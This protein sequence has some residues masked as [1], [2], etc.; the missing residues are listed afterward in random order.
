MTANP[1]CECFQCMRHRQPNW[2]EGF[3]PE[4]QNVIVE[5]RHYPNDAST[6]SG[7]DITQTRIDQYPYRA[8]CRICEFTIARSTFELA[9]SWSR[10][11]L[12][13]PEC[14]EHCDSPCRQCLG[15]CEALCETCGEHC[16]SSCEQCGE[17]HCEDW[18]SMCAAH[19]YHNH[20]NCENCH[21]EGYD[22]DDDDDDDY[23]LPLESYSY[24]PDPNFLGADSNL[25]LGLE[26]EVA[27]RGS[28]A[29]EWLNEFVIPKP[30]LWYAKEDSTVPGFEL[31]THPMTIRYAKT[32]LPYDAIARALD[33]GAPAT[34]DKCGTH[35]HISRNALSGRQWWIL[36]AIHRE[37]PDLCGFVGG[38][39]TTSEWANWSNGENVLKN[40][41]GAKLR[42]RYLRPERYTPINVTNDSTIELRYPMGDFSPNGIR[43]NVE[44]IEALTTYG[45]DMPA[46]ELAKSIN[47]QSF[48]QFINESN[49]EALKNTVRSY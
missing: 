27:W 5:L 2:Q 49:L 42:D 39:G 7:I 41:I 43:R 6:N 25:Y 31:V 11:H 18:C 10:E 26:L 9:V 21:E 34:N 30:S 19:C 48:I 47:E 33:D 4:E 14:G 35:I 8:T 38:R 45:R 23:R 3:S 16:D 37:L 20:P 15:H 22:D 1:Y 32:R 13:C 46:K 28:A 36:F 44:W 17:P 12:D 24:K 29:R 40:P